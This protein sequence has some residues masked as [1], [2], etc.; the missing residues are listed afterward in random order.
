MDLAQAFC[1]ILPMTETR[2]NKP[3]AGTS[4]TWLHVLNA[5]LLLGLWVFAIGAYPGLPE[6]VPGHIGGSGVTRWDAKQSSPWFILPIIALVNAAMMYGISAISHSTPGSF[7]VP[8]KT[9]LMKLPREGQRYAMA[10]M[11]GFM[12]GMATWLLVLLGY[13]QVE[14]Y[15]I[16]HAGPGADV[17][18]SGLL[19]VTILM[20]AAVVIM[21]VRMSGTVKRRIMEWEST[22]P[23]P[24]EA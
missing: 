23:T 1:N 13:I 20:V 16:A 12:Y 22:Q 5:V 3:D 4:Y 10:P 19:W 6:Q 18:T 8:A 7:N 14:M 9:Q 15:R 24:E 11:R 21:A 2:F 17:A